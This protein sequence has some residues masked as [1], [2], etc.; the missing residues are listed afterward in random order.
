VDSVAA[1]TTAAADAPAPATQT[2]AASTPAIKPALS[3]GSVV[4]AAAATGGAIAPASAAVVIVAPRAAPVIV[5]AKKAAAAPTEPSDAS[6]KK[7]AAGRG[8]A[9][10]RKNVGNRNNNNNSKN[11][12]KRQE[13]E[14]EAPA[15]AI[16]TDPPTRQLRPQRGG[17]AA[18]AATAAAAASDGR[19]VDAL[20][21]RSPEHEVP[22]IRTPLPVVTITMADV[23]A[24]PRVVLVQ[25]RTHRRHFLCPA[26]LSRCGGAIP[27]SA[28]VCPADRGFDVGEVVASGPELRDPRIIARTHSDQPIRVPLRFF[29]FSFV[30]DGA[31]AGHARVEPHRQGSSATNNGGT[32]P[33]SQ[34]R[35]MVSTAEMRAASDKG[36]FRFRNDAL[37]RIDDMSDWEIAQYRMPLP[38]LCRVATPAEIARA[39]VANEIHA[40][41]VLT[42]LELYRRYNQQYDHRSPGRRGARMADSGSRTT[43][44]RRELFNRAANIAREMDGEGWLGGVLDLTESAMLCREMMEECNGGGGAVDAATLPEP[45]ATEAPT[46]TV[47]AGAVDTLTRFP[48]FEPLPEGTGIA[49]LIFRNASIQADVARV[50]VYYDDRSLNTRILPVVEAL[51]HALQ[52]IHVRIWLHNLSHMGAMPENS[53]AY[54]PRSDAPS[55]VVARAV[56]VRQ[57]VMDMPTT[58]DEIRVDD[59]QERNGEPGG[60][61]QEGSEGGRFH[62]QAT[63]HRPSSQVQDPYEVAARRRYSY[64]KQYNTEMITDHAEFAGRRQAATM[65]DDTDRAYQRHRRTGA[66]TAQPSGAGAF[67]GRRRY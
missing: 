17:G 53:Y 15:A 38:A 60:A 12:S 39:N 19:S 35:Q 48:N 33:M 18:R 37:Q 66:Q 4:A 34:M 64:A 58:R 63:P 40:R 52:H 2:T 20:A 16:S 36:V 22:R 11:A 9:K 25:F 5:V 13:V 65:S 43:E 54:S 10:D 14:E 31:A 8:D 67:N 41:D 59:A 62:D 47:W 3:W 21:P 7:A 45:L 50:T 6:A 26:A 61:S 32:G 46:V 28:V 44:L 24:W 1:E 55:V 57:A 23:L 42:L 56:A 51:S 49:N 29:P 27:G 30:A